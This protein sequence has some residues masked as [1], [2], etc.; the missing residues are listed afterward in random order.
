MFIDLEL[1]FFF[2]FRA[3]LL[4]VRLDIDDIPVFLIFD[5]VVQCGLLESYGAEMALIVLVDNC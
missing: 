1:Q 3:A 4:P 5:M 2:N